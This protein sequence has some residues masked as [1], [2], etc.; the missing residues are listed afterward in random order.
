MILCYNVHE[1]WYMIDKI[2]IVHFGL[3]FALLHPCQPEKLKLNNNE[4]KNI[5]IYHHFIHMYQKSQLHDLQFLRY[6]APCTDR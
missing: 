6:G 2:F 3:F 4:Q 1:I 5:W